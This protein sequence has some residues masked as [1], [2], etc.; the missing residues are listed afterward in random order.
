MLFRSA[1]IVER[2]LYNGVI[3]GVSLSGDKF[4]YDNPLESMGQHGRQPWFGC[5]C[6]P[7][8]VTRFMASVP[9]YVY[10]TQANDIYVNL[11]VESTAD[12]N[13][14]NNNVKIEQTTDYPWDGKVELTITPEK[15]NEN[16]AIH[17]RIPGWAMNS[18]VPSDLYSYTDQR[19]SVSGYLYCTFA[20]N[21]CKT[22]YYTSKDKH[23]GNYITVERKWKSGDR[24]FVNLP[25]DVRKVKANDLVTDD[26]G[27][28]SMERG[29]VV[30]CIEGQDQE[31]N[32]VF[33]KFI[34]QNSEFNAEFKPEL[35]NG[36]TVLTGKGKEI[37]D[38]GE[39]KEVEI[40]AIPYYSWNNRGN[41]QMAVWIPEAQEY[42][43]AKP[44]PTLASQAR[45]LMIQ[46]PIQKDAPESAGVE[47]WAW[48]VNEDRK[49]VV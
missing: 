20:D 6:C 4:F 13:T 45:S 34:D 47:A 25:M 15:E 2:A 1:D 31:G 18:P 30:Y 19:N 5:A 3:S 12:I 48:G 9:N 37:G 42:A 8:N 7:G 49:S 41:D 38:N 43:R 11:F 23:D 28:F 29:P 16:F 27:K 44:Q 40:K 35:L 46:A 32:Y 22:K 36:V 26:I 21:G 10:A 39:I 24:V 17:F 33:N 14:K